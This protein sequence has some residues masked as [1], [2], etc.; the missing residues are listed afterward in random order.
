MK[1]T[2]GIF[3]GAG[4]PR[5]RPTSLVI[6]MVFQL[7]AWKTRSREDVSRCSSENPRFAN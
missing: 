1:K 5:V 3:V 6:A 2:A 7:I 4:M